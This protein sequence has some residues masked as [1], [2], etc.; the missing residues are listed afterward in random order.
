MGSREHACFSSA[1]GPEVMLGK[2]Q[3]GGQARAKAA[4]SGRW[5]ASL[6]CALAKLTGF[7]SH[8]LKRPGIFISHRP[9]RHFCELGQR[10]E[11]GVPASDARYRCRDIPGYHIDLSLL[12]S[13]QSGHPDLCVSA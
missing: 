12:L 10:K 2:T 3:K 8:P 5:A 13:M 1:L 7:F 4:P 6:R 11:I 9:P